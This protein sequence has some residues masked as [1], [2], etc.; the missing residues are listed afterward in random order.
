MYRGV[1]LFNML[2][3]NLRKEE[4]IEVFKNELS[5]WIKKEIPVKS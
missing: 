5:K 1:K 4:K 2:P 3:E